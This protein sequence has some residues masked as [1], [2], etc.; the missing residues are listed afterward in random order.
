MKNKKYLLKILERNPLGKNTLI[1]ELTEYQDT[2]L[3][4]L[5]EKNSKDKVEKSDDRFNEPF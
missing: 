5:D 2:I 3:T 4:D 1:V